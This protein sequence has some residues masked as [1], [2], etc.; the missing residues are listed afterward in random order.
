[1][2]DIKFPLIVEKRTIN[3]HL[4]NMRSSILFDLLILSIRI[5]GAFTLFNDVVQLIDLIN[6]S[7]SFALVCVL[8]WLDYPN[9]SRFFI[10]GHFKLFFF[11]DIFLSFFI[12]L[13]KSF[14]LAIFDTIF[15]MKS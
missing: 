12:V 15:N 6:H 1:M 7:D 3:V 5:S 14:V 2:S 9:V 8:S 13:D 10:V 11:F 4:H